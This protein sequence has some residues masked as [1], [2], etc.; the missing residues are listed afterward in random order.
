MKVREGEG[1]EWFAHRSDVVHKRN[2][3]EGEKR[4]WKR[5]KHEE[6]GFALQ[7]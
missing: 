5:F 2:L 3:M 4:K 6:Y 7:L 1:S